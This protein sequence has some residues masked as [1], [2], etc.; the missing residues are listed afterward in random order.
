MSTLTIEGLRGVP[1][2][3]I[4]WCICSASQVFNVEATGQYRKLFKLYAI[5]GAGRGGT[6]LEANQ[7]KVDIREVRIK[8]QLVFSCERG[9]KR[10]SHAATL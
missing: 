4:V 5:P 10:G 9:G 8:K 2:G 1:M 3:S 7:E 6:G